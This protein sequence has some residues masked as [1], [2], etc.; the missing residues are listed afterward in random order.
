MRTIRAWFARIAG[1]FRKEAGDRD[2]SAELEA[3]IE[4]HAKDN[5]RRGMNA[6]EARR[7]ALV[8][9]GGVE[10]VKEHYRDRHGLPWLENFLQDARFGVRM[11]RKNPGFTVVAVLT[12]ALGI[13]A[14]SAVFSV[15]NGVVLK[16]LPYPDPDRLNL[17]DL[18]GSFA[19]GRN[20]MG[21][22]DFLALRERQQA[23][24]DVAASSPSSLGFALSGFGEPQMIPGTE[25]TTGF[26]T[27]LGV[28]PVRGRAFL[29]EEGRAGGPLAVVVSDHFWRQFLGGD[30]AA[31]GR[32]LTL[33]DKSYTVVGVMP[34]GFRFG[35][36]AELW[37][38]MHFRTPD[39][40]PPY[41]LEV[42]GRRKPGVSDAQATA[43]ASRIAAEVQKQFPRSSESAAVA[44]PLKSIMVG[45][46]SRSLFLLLGAVAFVLLIAVVNVAA[47]Q[48]SRAAARSR[49]MAVRT[50]LGAG[51]ARLARQLLTESVL[52]AAAGGLVGLA[53]AYAGVRAILSLSPELPRA[54]EVAVDLS[55]LGFTAAIALCAGILFGLA[56]IFQS[57]AGSV[58]EGLKQGT[59]SAAAGPST[60]RPHSVLVVAEFSLAL[61]VLVGAGL[62]IRTLYL[63]QS[64]SPGF[65]SS[66]LVTAMLSLP[67]PRYPEPPQLTAF[68]DQLL[69]RVSNSPGVE[70]AAITLSLPPNLLE[71]TN[72]FHIEGHPE[73]PG[74][75]DP[76]VPEIPI[77][78]GYF[79]TLG[80]PLYR[81]RFFNNAD[82]VPGTHVLIVNETMARRYFPGG[83]AVGKRVST[84]EYDPKAEL[85]T[86]VGVVG[87]V[88]YEGL[89]SADQPAMYVPYHDSGWSPWFVHNMYVVAR[90]AT[91]TSAANTALRSAVASLDKNLP[92]IRQRTMD[93]LLYDSVVGSRFRAILFALFGALALVLAATGIYG[94]MAYSVSQRT[95]EI[96]IRMALGAER[97]RVFGLVLSEALRLALIGVA[98]GLFASLLLA[99]LLAS[100]MSSLLFGVGPY[101]PLALAGA[102][103]SLEVL[104][105]I[106]G[107][108]PAHRAM[109]IDPNAALRGE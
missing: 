108:I 87:D 86:I 89:D 68:Y 8:R 97:G 11:L 57:A 78:D 93:E 43:D 104:A 80:V 47:L 28:Q 82:R 55:V 56:P 14:N 39:G 31:V 7:Q 15:V 32:K 25:V 20:P 4:L 17:I 88:K 2:L 19:P 72:P 109:S 12:L 64:V 85:Y 10:A 16:P 94:V 96:A 38:A 69:E 53:F 21:A 26:F 77:S 73:E 6:T 27:V 40:R 29:E 59:R 101:D 36:P 24:E 70:G 91:S 65:N 23:F 60:R 13:G 66:R 75:P 99:R 71:L 48:L 103:A 61:V 98:L 5:M 44:L 34:P 58:G 107:Y 95:P 63:T 37:P 79:R 102:A 42:I 100:V 62:L 67:W 46:E 52:L 30:P 45:G 90:S 49:E 50:A 105:L 35:R 3:N 51:R 1:F 76:A 33:N 54:H 18:R 84:G 22:A 81:G 74:H 83:D 9:L 41:Y 92:I 106:A